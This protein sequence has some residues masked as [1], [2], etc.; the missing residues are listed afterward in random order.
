MKTFL[1]IIALLNVDPTQNLYTYKAVKIQTEQQS[2]S[3]G[4]LDHICDTFTVFTPTVY[5]V[6]QKLQIK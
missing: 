4:K 3:T 6:G 1:V 2:Q 5:T